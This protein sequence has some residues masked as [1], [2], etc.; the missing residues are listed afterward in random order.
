VRELDLQMRLG[1]LLRMTK[2]YA[3]EEVG[4]T[5]VR[6]LELCRE[7]GAERQML[8]SLWR[9]GV[10]YEVRG[11]YSRT[12]EI[13]KEVLELGERSGEATFRMVARVMLG[14]AAM[15]TG[16]L[17]DSRE[18]LEEAVALADSPEGASMETVGHDLQ[19]TPRCFLAQTLTL[20]GDTRRAREMLAQAREHSQRH[21]KLL[22]E[23]LILFMDAITAVVR[24][25]EGAARTLAEEL[26]DLCST[27]GIPVYAAM[28]TMIRGWVIGQ[29][30][31]PDTG[32][33][34]VAEGLA[35]FRATGARML[36]DVYQCLLAETLALAGRPREALAAIEEGLRHIEDSGGFYAAE[37]H[38]L[39]GV[40]LCGAEPH[41][42]AE[43]ALSLQTAVAV[44]R[45][46][47]A[48]TLTHRATTSLR[49]VMDLPTPP[50]RERDTG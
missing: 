30:G 24:H 5:C 37:L 36:L 1:G 31:E 12:E 16:R 21:P 4:T 29:H 47:K 14:A 41:R 43:A 35:A 40:T 39:R 22:D 6:T 46:Q 7:L 2:G 18:H 49:A 45:E 3:A 34:I 23:A 13:G 33:R 26:F 27:R 44:A 32:V 48:T 42:Q 17:M 28:A 9:F 50:P 10:F 19:V 25:E 20:L 11:E 38:R 8:A 15:H